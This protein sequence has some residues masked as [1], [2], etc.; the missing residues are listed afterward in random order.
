MLR[1]H[2]CLALAVGVLPATLA[3]QTR[4]LISIGDHRLEVLRAGTGRPA[5]IFETGLADSLDTWAPLV[6][7]IGRY[8]TAIAYSRAGFG[9]SEA[10]SSD[11]SAHAEVSDLHALLS[12]LGLQP[13]Y[14]LVG[15]SY[16]GLLVRLY[17]SLYPS[18]VAGLVL[19]DGT[20][21]RQVRQFG[22]LDAR[23]PGQFRAYFDSVLRTLPAGPRAAE[24]RETMRIQDAGSVEGLQPLPDIPLAVLTSMKA[25]SNARYVY[26]TREGH[27]VWRALHEEWFRRSTN[28]EHVVTTRSGHD[29]QAD[30]PSLVVDAIRFVLERAKAAAASMHRGPPN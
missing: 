4:A 17:T 19:V 16:G 21:E 3:A 28:A 23:Y 2:N 22:K 27:Q 5:V 8:T 20:H 12:H 29:I 10:G 7:V 24:I 9:R 25:D 18:D 13:P 6:P 11:H 30:E 15:R 26:A 14:V 1:L